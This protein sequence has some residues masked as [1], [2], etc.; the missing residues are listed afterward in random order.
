MSDVPIKVAIL[1]WMLLSFLK[2]AIQASEKE[3]LRFVTTDMEGVSYMLQ[4]SENFIR[5]DSRSVS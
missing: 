2:V 1:Y 4:L 3:N 5:P